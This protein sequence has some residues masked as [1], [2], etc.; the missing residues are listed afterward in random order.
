METKCN[1]WEIVYLD[2]DKDS[3]NEFKRFTQII[4]I[5]YDRLDGNVFIVGFELPKIS[6]VRFSIQLGNHFWKI[7]RYLNNWRIVLT[8]NYGEKFHSWSHPQGFPAYSAQY[9]EDKSEP[10]HFKDNI[11]DIINLGSEGDVLSPQKIYDTTNEVEAYFEK[12]RK[13]QSVNES[14]LDDVEKTEVNIPTNTSYDETFIPKPGYWDYSLF[15]EVDKDSATQD[16]IRIHD[17]LEAYADEYNIYTV[18][19]PESA[20]EIELLMINIVAIQSAQKV[21]HCI[22]YIVE[23]NCHRRPYALLFFLMSV[24]SC[25]IMLTV[26]SLRKEY[27]IYNYKQTLEY[28]RVQQLFKGEFADTNE[29]CK[30][31]NYAISKSNDKVKRSKVKNFIKTIEERI[32]E[33]KKSD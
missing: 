4:D 28:I 23:F 29:I 11:E 7:I 8:K 2:W 16:F 25:G 10:E 26:P 12:H 17:Y 20:K 1:D 21:R 15:F 22:H 5:D 32:K 3:I 31:I 33:K 13:K 24:G 27:K 18:D 14:I 30:S 9:V 19:T 6:R